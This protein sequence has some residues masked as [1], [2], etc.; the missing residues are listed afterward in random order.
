MKLFIKRIM[1]LI[2]LY[3]AFTAKTTRKRKAI[4]GKCSYYNR[5]TTQC[6]GF[7]DV[8]N[9]GTVPCGCFMLIKRLIPAARC[10]DKKW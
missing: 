6:G 3:S 8:G 9:D 5:L 7:G 2:K 4:C 1:I 10:P